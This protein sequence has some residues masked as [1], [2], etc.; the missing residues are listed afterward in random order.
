MKVKAQITKVEELRSGIATNGLPYYRRTIVIA[1]A[2]PIEGGGTYNNAM[3]INLKGEDA[4]QNYQQF[5]QVELDVTFRVSNFKSR[6]Y[7]EI[8]GVIVKGAAIPQQVQQSGAP[9]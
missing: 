8:D 4:Q 5:Q 9:F 6:W 2:E 3:C 1:Y 7:Q